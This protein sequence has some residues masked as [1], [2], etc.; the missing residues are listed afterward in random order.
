MSPGRAGGRKAGPG[1]EG[2]GAA[3]GFLGVLAFSLTLPATRAAVPELGGVVV[4]LGRAVVAAA[5]A[6][7]LLLLLRE[8]PPARRHRRGLAIVALGVVI[9]FPLC[10]ALAL[11]SVPAVHGAVVVGLLP[12]ATAIMAVARA[13][14]RPPPAFWLASAVGVGAV[15][16]FAAAQGAGRPQPADGLL[17]AAVVLGALGYAEGGR[18][19]REMGGWRVICWALVLAGP[20]LTPPVLIVAV[21]DGLDAGQDAW[22]GFGYVSLVSMF[23]GFF[24]WYRG[25]ALGG[26]ARVGQIQ[27]LQPVLTLGWAALLL[28]E[29]VDRPTLLASGLVI[30]SVALTRLSWTQAGSTRRR[31]RGRSP[32]ESP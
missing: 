21:R 14:E 10:S 29:A 5:L 16:V 24:A 18:L 3:Y 2:W 7:A 25:L 13:G 8:R 4:G 1:A 26:V 15:L 6:G 19:A 31:L 9:G 28:G 17:L 23:L 27:L 20:V 11:R 30:G 32:R 22:L 12:A